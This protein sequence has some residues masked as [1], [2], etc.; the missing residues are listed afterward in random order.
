MSRGAAADGCVSSLGDNFLLDEFGGVCDGSADELVDRDRDTRHGI[1][2]PDFGLLDGGS[3]ENAEENLRVLLGS[4]KI[5]CSEI[6]WGDGPS[7]TCR[8]D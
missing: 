2:M 7:G 6:R 3:L 5:S 1:V 8:S 4:E